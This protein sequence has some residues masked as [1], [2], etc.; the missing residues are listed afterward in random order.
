MFQIF[1]PLIYYTVCI[2]KYKT[3]LEGFCW[4]FLSQRYHI[5]LSRV[6]RLPN[7]NGII[8]YIYQIISNIII[9]CKN[10]GVNTC[11]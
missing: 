4:F 5:V 6:Y 3:S 10:T 8:F 11:T 2:Q 1:R 7:H 9:T